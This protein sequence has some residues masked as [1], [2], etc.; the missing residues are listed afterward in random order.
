M[1]VPADMGDFAAAFVREE[2]R[3]QLS[4]PVIVGADIRDIVR[5]LPVERYDRQVDMTVILDLQR[6]AAQNDAVDAAGAEHVDVFRFFLAV[7]KGV[8][9]QQPV[10]LVVGILFNMADQFAEERVG[11]IRNDQSNE[12]R[13]GAAE[14]TGQLVGPIMELVHGL[15]DLLLELL[16]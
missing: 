1:G 16:A 3:R 13:F 8:A 12:V 4:A 15:V 9:Q 7:Q 2:R 5:Y 6:M 10:T 11:R 14:R